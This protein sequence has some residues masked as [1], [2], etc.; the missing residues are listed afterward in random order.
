MDAGRIAWQQGGREN[1]YEK[2][3]EVELW[4]RQTWESE[5]WK[6]E[7]MVVQKLQVSKRETWKH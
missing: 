4:R 1:Y 3:I 6:M 2:I 5:A 7:G